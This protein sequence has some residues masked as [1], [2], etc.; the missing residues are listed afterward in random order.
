MHD[1]RIK[2][3][4]QRFKDRATLMLQWIDPDTGRRKS[5]S[6]ETDDEGTAETKR[7]DLE[8]KLNNGL[9]QEASK[10]DWERFRELI[11]GE[12]LPGLR[13]RSRE[14]YDTVLD[15]FEQTCKPS[16]LRAVSER[17]ISQF[18]KALRERRRS[19]EKV[20]LAP[21][22]IK[23]YLIALKSAL[24]WAVGQKLLPALPTFPVVKVPKKK[25]QPIPTESFEKLLAKAPDEYWRTYLLC[26]WWAGL[27]LSE[28]LHL[29]WERNDESP[30]VDFDRDRIVLPA[31]FAKA[32][33][34][35]WVP[36]H[37]VLRES[38]AAMPRQR[39]TVFHF[40]SNRGGLLSRSAVT[41][42]IL[43]LAKQA[44]VRLSMHKLRKGFGCRAAQQ[45]GK[46][47]AP[48]LH[49]LMRHSSMQVTMD[50][51]ASVDDSLH[52]AINAL[53]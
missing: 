7:G 52:E 47:N 30:W 10:L 25:P 43:R 39:V 17:T 34:D 29:R 31:V 35:Q 11:T 46:G 41:H 40:L 50:Y 8:Y 19:K 49:T 33:T 13:P 27:R 20:G 14:K 36:L 6:A 16:K 23:N 18:V 28:A 4:V 48:I 26:G 2:V 38:L 21:H 37:P 32:D 22:T 15:V 3:W 44:G 42:R 12:Y 53:T 45:L 24:G 51:Y 5:Q 9:H 1:K